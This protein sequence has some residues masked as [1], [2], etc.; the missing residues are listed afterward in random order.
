MGLIIILLSFGAWVV[1]L[2]GVGASQQ[3]CSSKGERL[4]YVFLPHFSLSVTARGSGIASRHAK[5]IC[6]DEL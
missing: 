3:T 6:F 4:E 5:S 2:G 1:A